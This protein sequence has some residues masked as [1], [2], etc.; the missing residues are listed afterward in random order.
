[1]INIYIYIV[2]HALV[3]YRFKIQYGSHRYFLKTK[4]N[5]YSWNWYDL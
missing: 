5:L 4:M 2:L 3:Q 1:M